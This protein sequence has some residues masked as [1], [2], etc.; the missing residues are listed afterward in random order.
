M[1]VTR[2]FAAVCV[3]L[4]MLCAVPAGA[5]EVRRP[6]KVSFYFAAHEDD[7][8]LFMNPSAFQDVMGGAAKT[9]FVYLTAGDDG[10]GLGSRGRKHPYYLAR[11]NGAEQA[12][13][14][15]ADT[16]GQPVEKIVS[17]TAFNGHAIYRIA[18]R[19]TVSYF[20][21]VPDGHW[22]GEGYPKTGFQSLLRLSTGA[23]HTLRAIDGSATYDSWDDL[24]K[25]LRALIDFE[26]G[27]AAQVQ[28]NVAETDVHINPQDHSDHIMTAKA[29]LDAVKDLACVQ[30]AYYVD[31][32]SSK[33]PENLTAQQRDME[34]SVFAVTLAGILALD[35]PANWHHYDTSFV[36]RNYFRISAG[37]GSCAPRTHTAASAGR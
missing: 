18:Y 28:L 19:N 9:V 24:T 33:L 26:R 17:H 32:A 22:S 7:W 4:A 8:Q 34:S 14:F 30:R 21:R 25:T 31:Y 29:A 16:N 15:M 12:V 23:N 3:A 20:L 2:S 27:Q 5:D 37:N 35:H 36:G 11:E 1:T 13:R 10:A 6:D